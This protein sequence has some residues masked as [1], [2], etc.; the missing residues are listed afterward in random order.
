[1]VGAAAR[2]SPSPSRRGGSGGR[3]GR[4]SWNVRGGHVDGATLRLQVGD[5]GPD[6][7]RRELLGHRRHDG[8]V[9]RHDVGLGVVERLVQVLLAVLLGFA[10]AA[11]GADR[12]GALIVGEEIGRARAESM[13]GGA[14]ADAVE[15]LLYSRLLL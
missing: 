4:G 11:A 1:G 3:G 8:L 14:H 12:P 6:L 9:A 15:A 13:A 10:L 5:H 7:R 2:Q